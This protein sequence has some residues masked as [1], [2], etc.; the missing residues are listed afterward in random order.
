MAR[1]M[2]RA[3]AWVLLALPF[4]ALLGVGLYD[5]DAP[6]LV[7]IPFF[8]WYQLTWIPLGAVLLWAAAKLMDHGR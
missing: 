5:R 4:V 7:G 3:A 6:R 8:Y 1:R 2:R